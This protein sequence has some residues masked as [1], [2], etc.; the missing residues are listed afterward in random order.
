[1]YNG[2]KEKKMKKTWKKDHKNF[3]VKTVKMGSLFEKCTYS[4]QRKIKL[5]VRCNFLIFVEICVC[6]RVVAIF[7]WQ[8]GSFFC[9][10]FIEMATFSIITR[11]L[12]WIDSMAQHITL[13]DQ[14]NNNPY[15]FVFYCTIFLLILVQ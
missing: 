2:K 12:S 11:F 6:W 3:T 15:H 4:N 5:I 7:M 13:I 10:V 1:M 14:K 9:T 8:K